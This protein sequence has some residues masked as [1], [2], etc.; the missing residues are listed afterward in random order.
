[1]KILYVSRSVPHNKVS[2]AGGKTFN[3]YIKGIAKHSND[4]ITLVSFGEKKEF[5]KCDC[6]K[7]GIET[8]FINNFVNSREKFIDKIYKC[9]IGGRYC[10]I[11]NLSSIKKL[12]NILAELIKKNYSPDVIILEWAQMTILIDIVKNFFPKAK[13]VASEHDV[14]Y[15][16]L[17]RKAER[18]TN[19]FKKIYRYI[20]YHVTKKRECEALLKCDLILCHNYKDV[21]LLEDNG[22]SG[23][24]SIVP[25]YD[26]YKTEEYKADRENISFLGAMSREEN[27]K[28]VIWFIKNVLPELKDYDFKFYVLGSNPPKKLKQLE[29][30][31]IKITGFVD[32]MTP[33]LNNTKF[34]V[35]PLLLGAGIKV[36]VLEFAAAGIPVL[37]NN[38]GIEGIPF[39]KNVDYLHSETKDEFITTI[40]DALNDK[41]NL[42][43]ISI[44]ARK[45][46]NINFNLEESLNRYINWIHMLYE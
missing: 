14:Y 19:P 23:A 4:S 11:H 29:D 38:I 9:N 34:A 31:K 10:G 7:Y 45:K 5:N 22:V 24:K 26:R 21:K 44:N 33:Y 37:T 32:N 30:N 1:M 16:G 3:Y 46:V 27:Y 12:K 2:H 13:Y 8:Y 42:D 41:I 6:A 39:E 43:V 36:K 25:Y 35:L 20:K 28:S 17:E 15:L 18:E 40:K